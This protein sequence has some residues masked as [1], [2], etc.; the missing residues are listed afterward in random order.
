MVQGMEWEQD[1]EEKV[2]DKEIKLADK[3]AWKY[4]MQ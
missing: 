3:N 1:E 4:K 2:E